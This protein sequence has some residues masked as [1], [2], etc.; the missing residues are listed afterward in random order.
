M[1]TKELKKQF[2]EVGVKV[3]EPKGVTKCGDRTNLAVIH[4]GIQYVMYHMKSHHFFGDNQH[5]S[6]SSQAKKY[7]E[8]VKRHHKLIKEVHGYIQKKYQGDLWVMSGGGAQLQAFFGNETGYLA[9]LYLDMEN[10]DEND[11]LEDIGRKGVNLVVNGG[12]NDEHFKDF[13]MDGVK[14]I[15]H[16]ELYGTNIINN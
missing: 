4:D 15:T 9:I 1:I 12:R 14:L 13:K 6:V 5:S 10:P 2:A 8:I 11:M 16:K 7:E 3:V